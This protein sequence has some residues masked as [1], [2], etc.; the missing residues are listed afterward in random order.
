MMDAEHATDR[1][2]IYAPIRART[3]ARNWSR[4]HID[5]DDRAP[6]GLYRPSLLVR[7][8]RRVGA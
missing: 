1:C 5:G 6:A 7:L 2:D 3:A 4:V 8:M